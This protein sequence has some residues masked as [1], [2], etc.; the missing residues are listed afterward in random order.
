MRLRAFLICVF[1]P[2]FFLLFCSL[3]FAQD[4]LQIFKRTDVGLFPKQGGVEFLIKN[5]TKAKIEANIASLLT[6]YKNRKGIQ[7]D[8]FDDLE[9]LQRRG[10]EKYPSKSV[11]KHWLVSITDEKIFRFYLKERTDIK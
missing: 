2:C 3:P 4:D 1:V 9:A 8:I 5:P 11:Y 7:I 6:T 10:D